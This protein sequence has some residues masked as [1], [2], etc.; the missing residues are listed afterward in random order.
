MQTLCCGPA[1]NKPPRPRHQSAVP[2]SPV[3]LPK[4]IF[5]TVD[6]LKPVTQGNNLATHV[7]SAHTVPG[8]PSP[9][10]S[11]LVECLVRDHTAAPS[12]SP[13]PAEYGARFLIPI[14]SRFL[15]FD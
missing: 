13:Q 1:S 5:T 4:S 10:R 2:P 3:K 7:L 15:R 14:L 11:T 6:Q 12:S 8:K 9:S